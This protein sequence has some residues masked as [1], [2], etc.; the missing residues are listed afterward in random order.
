VKLRVGTLALIGFLLLVVVAFAT[1]AYRLFGS[2]VEPYVLGVPFFFAWTV[3]WLLSAFLAL[4]AY[5]LT[6]SRPE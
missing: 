4:V 2:D 3:A 5:H 1:P 6:R